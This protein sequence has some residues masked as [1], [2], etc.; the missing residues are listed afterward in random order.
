MPPEPILDRDE[1]LAHERE[2]FARWTAA[3]DRLSPDA[4]R[5]DGWTLKEVVAHLAAWHRVAE[6]RLAR[7][8]AGAVTGPPGIDAWNDRVRAAASRQTW[9]EVDAE[10]ESARAALLARVEATAPEVLRAHDGLG[11][12]IVGANGAFHYEEHLD[13]FTGAGG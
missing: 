12:F 7:L 9:A 8:A 4:R 3:V 5:E 2:A 13:D 11:A 6:E 1:L 10:A